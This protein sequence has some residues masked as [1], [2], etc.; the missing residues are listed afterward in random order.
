MARRMGLAA[1]LCIGALAS[2]AASAG[3]APFVAVTNVQLD[4]A[5]ATVTADVR[6]DAQAAS[7][8]QMRHGTVRLVAVSDGKHRATFLGAAPPNPDVGARPDQRVS[9]TVSVA[10]RRAAMAPGNR[11]VLT[12]TQ[13][14]PPGGA[15]VPRA[16]VTVAQAQPYAGKQ[17]HIGTDDC[18]DRPVVAGAQLDYCDLVGADLENVL[19]SLHA[20]S[21]YECQRAT[22]SSCLRRADLSGAVL[23]AANLSGANLA[24]A[25]LNDA[26]LRSAQLDNVSLI[27]A[28]AV[29]IDARGSTS[30]KDATATAA[31]L[32]AETFAAALEVCKDAPQGSA[33][34]AMLPDT[35]ERYLSTPLFTDISPD[36]NDEERAILQSTPSFAS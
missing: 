10:R 2:F 14:M 15:R 33:I 18:S 3:A 22:A 30:D 24:G 25:R 7:T 35:G 16:Y 27:G 21:A 26:D 1:L 8:A 34:L 28:D 6:W 32:C 36:M 20:P 31:D 9:I 12:A 17:P 23:R 5:S 19:V 13:K 29:G 11:I 4:R